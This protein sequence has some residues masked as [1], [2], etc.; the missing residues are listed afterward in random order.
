M[1]K[2]CKVCGETFPLDGF[3]AH[4]KAKDGRDATCK[5]CRKAKVRANRE[6]KVDYYREFDRQRG[7]TQKRRDAV[8]DYRRRNPDK[9]RDWRQAYVDRHPDR[10]AES[11]RKSNAKHPDRRK[12]R[13]AVGN[14]V[15]DGRL[16]KPD[17]CSRCGTKAPRIEGHHEDYSKP[18]DVTWLCTLC[19]R[20]YT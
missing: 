19:H 10:I 8:D 7:K 11:H 3:Y 6:A 12:A 18:L 9:V 5:E 20:R 2:P 4:P 1:D 15:R 14:A 13:Q 17:K 16:D